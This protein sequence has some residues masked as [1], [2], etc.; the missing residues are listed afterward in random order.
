MNLTPLVRNIKKRVSNRKFQLR[1]VR[2]YMNEHAAILVYKQ[3]IMPIF[4]YAGHL[5]ISTCDG[6]KHDLQVMQN[7]AKYKIIR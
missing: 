6:V 4:D 3:T 1:K 7:D 2:K 5:L